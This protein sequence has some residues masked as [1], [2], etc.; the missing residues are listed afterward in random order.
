MWR[1]GGAR[2]DRVKR[3][4]KDRDRWRCRQCGKAGILEVDHIRRIEDGG[5]EYELANCQTLC[6]GCHIRKTNTENGVIPWPA[7]WSKLVVNLT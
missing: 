7:D 1:K 2:W 5:P 3:K 6:R 4:A